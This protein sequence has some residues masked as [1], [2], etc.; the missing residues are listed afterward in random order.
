MSDGH[1][2]KQF[3][4]KTELASG[5]RAGKAQ[6]KA[7]A[8]QAFDYVMDEMMKNESVEKKK[9]MKELFSDLLRQ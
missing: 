1:F 6:M 3:L 4:P 2:N 5:L 9:A 7:K 8:E